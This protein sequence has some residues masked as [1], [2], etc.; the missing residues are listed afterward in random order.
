MWRHDLVRA[1]SDGVPVGRLAI[2]QEGDC[3]LSEHNQAP[4]PLT[5]PGK[6]V[7]ARDV[8]VITLAFVVTMA[9]MAVALFVAR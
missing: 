8:F 2:E 1:G 9:M 7:D 6:P 4:R 3:D 5:H